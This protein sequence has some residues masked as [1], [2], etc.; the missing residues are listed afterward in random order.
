MKHLSEF[1][2]LFLVFLELFYTFFSKV[3]EILP[4]ICNLNLCHFIDVSSDQFYDFKNAYLS[5]MKNQNLEIVS[6]GIPI[7]A[8]S[9]SLRQC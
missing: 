6:L 5:E 8:S 2:Y 3:L 4:H 1:T 9:C 7:F